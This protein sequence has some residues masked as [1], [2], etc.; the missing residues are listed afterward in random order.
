[1][2]MDQRVTLTLLALYYIATG[3]W[4]IVDVGSF[5]KITGPK[6]DLWLV[7]CTGGLVAAVGVALIC[8]LFEPQLPFTIIALAAAVAV[9]LTIVDIVYVV[10]GVISPIYIADACIE[11]LLLAA[12]VL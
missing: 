12:L 11:A 3:L 10:K 8:S 1:M 9:T 4:P 2:S 6:S 7:K 5:Q